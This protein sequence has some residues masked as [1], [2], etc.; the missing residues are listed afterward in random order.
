MALVVDRKRIVDL[1]EQVV[2]DRRFLHERPELA[3]QEHETARFVAERLQQLGLE[4]RTGVG[5]TGVVGL[6]RGGKPGPTLLM[7]ADMDALPILEQNDVPYRSRTEGKMHACGHDAHTAIMLG[8]ARV[9]A[10]TREELPGT[11]KFVFQPAEEIGQGA[12]AMI[13][14]GVLDDPAVDAA[15]GLHIWQDV[16]AG[17]VGVSSGP[18]MA[19]SDDFTATIRGKGGHAAM[20]DTTVDATLIACQIVVGLQQIVSR[21]ISPLQPAVV[22]VGTFQAGTATNVIA[23]EAVFTGSVRSFDPAVRRSLAERIPAF[24]Q[25]MALSMR[26]EAMVDYR[27]GTPP[28]TNDPAFSDL[29]QRAAVE[30]VGEENILTN[31]V[32]TGSE[33]MS[34]FLEAAPGCYFFIGSRDEASGKIY[35]HHHPRFDVDEDVFAIGVEMLVRSAL[36]YLQQ[37]QS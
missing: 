9:L 11:V 33:D 26:A 30:V 16:P 29:V 6:L 13:A 1:S 14:D 10:Q 27:L 37:R 7:R 19:A 3:F 32:T 15:C 31:V 35:G 20:P 18:V 22:T 2:S 25:A 5:K 12:A 24:I 34:L 21:E 17:K 23:S 28:V 4:V 36:G 8:V